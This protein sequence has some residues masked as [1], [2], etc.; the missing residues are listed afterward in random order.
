MN[1]DLNRNP[2]LVKVYTR[3]F[4]ASAVY[5][6]HGSGALLRRL[7]TPAGKQVDGVTRGVL[8]FPLTAKIL[9]EDDEC[10]VGCN[11]KFFS[12]GHAFCRPRTNVQKL[13]Q[14]QVNCASRDF[15]LTAGDNELSYVS[16]T[17]AET[18]QRLDHV[19]EE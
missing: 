11:Q 19:G 6:L 12:I 14:P 9:K 1:S 16:K 13:C 8:I 5:R 7:R 3:L 4:D 17:W 18:W 15:G 10:I 2:F